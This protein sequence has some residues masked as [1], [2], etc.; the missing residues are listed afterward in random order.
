MMRV[1]NE[2]KQ[3]RE[4]MRSVRAKL[5]LEQEKEYDT[6]S[7][8]F[9]NALPQYLWHEWKDEIKPQGFTWQKFSHLLRMRTDKMVG[10]F[11]G[12]NSW[13]EL[14][15]DIASLIESPVG[16]DIA[17]NKNGST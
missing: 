7:V 11:R 17:K 13:E 9:R 6:F 1:P 4:E 15:E 16:Q 8:W 14:A 10:W 3:L 12:L 5:P 2:P